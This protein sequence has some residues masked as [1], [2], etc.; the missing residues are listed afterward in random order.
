MIRVNKK[1]I[2][3]APAMAALMTLAPALSPGNVAVQAAEAPPVPKQEWG[4]KGITGTFDRAALQRG[5]LVYAQVCAACH[6]M[7]RLYFRNLSALGYSE[8]QVTA[9]AG[10]YVVMDGPDEDGEMFE[11]PAR[12][13]DPFISPY[14]NR[15][16]AMFANNG[17]FPPDLSLI[18]KARYGGADYIYA[19]LTGYEEPPEGEELFAGQYW[20]A[21]MPGHVIAMAPPLA[22]GMI[23]YED[24]TPETVSQYSRDLAEFLAWASEPY[25]EERK[26]T[27]IKVFL[28]LLVFTGLMY[29]VKK[30]VWAGQYNKS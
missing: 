2:F 20:N 19:L 16:A 12:P 25:M 14:P 21:Y 18:A 1:N 13:S 30:K 10:D 8:G 5:Y 27:G 23:A 17:A 29:A 6:G 28:F 15:Q 22:D 7:D 9:I 11:R 24:G 4:F 3:L 26:R